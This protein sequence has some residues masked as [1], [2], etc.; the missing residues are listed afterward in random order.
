MRM[1]YTRQKYTAAV[2]RSLMTTYRTSLGFDA[3]DTAKFR[4]HCIEAYTLLGWKGLSICYP[5]LKRRTFFDWRHAYLAS[6]RKLS[7]LVPVSTKPQHKRQMQVPAALVAQIRVYRQ[8]YP[9]LGKTKLKVLLDAFCLDLGYTSI[10]A[11]TI[12]KVLTRYH[13][14]YAGK[15]CPKKKRSHAVSR[16][17][18]CPRAASL[19]PGY[20]QI[21]G[22]K[23]WAIDRYYYLLTAVDIVT[24]QAW[25][26]VAS[27]FSSAQARALLQEVTT[28]SLH[29]I[30]TIQTDNGSEFAGLFAQA[31]AQDT[32]LLH[33]HSSPKSPTSNGYI[34]RFN[35]TIQDE[36]LHN[37]EAFLDQDT[38]QLE[39]DLTQWLHFYHHVR[40]H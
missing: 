32:G 4:L 36:F 12:G 11:S 24:K 39:Q 27:S 34:E 29:P 20:V 38:H 15:A 3:S 1:R 13:M 9:R 33:L 17:K 8:A 21:D 22:T 23:E 37:C 6:S 14:F 16:L 26:R 35:W 10:S 18:H 30:H 31:L 19:A 28:T 25:V 2:Y 7:S 40:P 5:S